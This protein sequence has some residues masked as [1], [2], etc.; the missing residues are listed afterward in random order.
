MNR[1]ARCLVPLLAL[2]LAAAC[3]V[4]ESGPASV[5]ASAAA[6]PAIDDGSLM[7]PGRP[8]LATLPAV[9]SPGIQPVSWNMW[10]GENAREWEVSVNGQRVKWGLL[11]AASPKAQQG[12]IELPLE[13]PGQYEIRVSL[14]NDHGCSHSAPAV[15]Q[16]GAG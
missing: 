7:L 14:C 4:R 6:A 10:W 8:Q 16:V 3:N 9:A 2:T 11:E 12:R 5:V 1:P 13:Q 15:L